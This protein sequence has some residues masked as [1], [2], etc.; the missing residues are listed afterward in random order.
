MRAVKVKYG[1]THAVTTEDESRPGKREIGI[2]CNSGGIEI[3]DDNGYRFSVY[4]A[5]DSAITCYT[6]REANGLN[7]QEENGNGN[8]HPA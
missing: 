3:T 5:D 6:C 4:D 2:S 7:H 1:E 8:N